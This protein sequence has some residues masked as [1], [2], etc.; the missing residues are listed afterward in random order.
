MSLDELYDKIFVI[1]LDRRADRMLEI[2]KAL[3]RI[4]VKNFERVSAVDGKAMNKKFPIAPGHVGC[5]L[6]HMKVL[7]LAK[8]RGYKNYIVFEDDAEFHPDFVS[9]FDEK[10]KFV[11][12]NWDC[13]FFGGSHVGGFDRLNEHVIKMHGSYTTHAMIINNSLYEK[14][15]GVWGDQS[16]RS[17]VDVAMARLHKDNNCYSFNPP[18]V[19]QKAGY[20]DILDKFDDYKHLRK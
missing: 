7:N 2:S 15:T 5:V 3:D 19:F 6:S 8:E 20:S 14:L 13:V 10:I 18:L 16:F 12:E 11:P 1:N 17:E 9:L 4:G